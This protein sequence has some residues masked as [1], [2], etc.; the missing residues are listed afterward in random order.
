MPRARADKKRLVKA[1]HI[2]F[3]AITITSLLKYRKAVRAFLQWRADQGHAMPVTLTALDILFSEYSNALYVGDEPMYKAADA[4]SGLKRYY[5]QCR[6]HLDVSHAF[7]SYWAKSVP[8]RR[9][10]PLPPS[11]VQGM[12]A[13]AFREDKPVIG[14]LF[15]CAFLG[16]FR[17]GELLT[18]TAGQVHRLRPN[19]LHVSLP[20][21]KGAQLKGSPEVVQLRD[22]SVIRLLTQ[23]CST[24]QP[25]D[26]IFPVSYYSVFKE[27]RHTA[28]FFGG[29]VVGLSPHSFHRGGATWLFQ[30]LGTAKTYVDSA[31][32]D[33]GRFVLSKE[34][35][36]K[37]ALAA[38]TLP[39][40]MRRVNM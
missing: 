15:L 6:K 36:A 7:Y 12:A 39:E 17:V 21:S 16:L 28:A 13:V 27:M 8:R 1:S 25:F 23:R 4:L 2:K 35:Q 26:L 32:S 5:P 40:A 19:L 10:F 22:M 3:A 29:N 20:N 14:L 33:S 9:A 37:L 11:W 24:I 34:N 31:L 30:R 18:L 38:N